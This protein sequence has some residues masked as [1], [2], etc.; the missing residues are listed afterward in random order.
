MKLLG[1]KRVESLKVCV[2]QAIA[3][4]LLAECNL[5]SLPRPAL[6]D[7]VALPHFTHMSAE[8]L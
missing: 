6:T 7:A 4:V 1:R 3:A 8:S 2:L 5:P